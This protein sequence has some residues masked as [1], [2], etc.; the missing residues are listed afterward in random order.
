MALGGSVGTL[1]RYLLGAA[2]PHVSGVPIGIFAINISGALALGFVVQF[3]AQRGR[4]EGRR[5]SLRLLIGTGVLGGYTT[6]SLLAADIA[7]LVL[8][9][10]A[11]TGAGYGI[12]T[13][14]VGL[15]ATWCGVWLARLAKAGR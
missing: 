9:G 7:E 6:Y 14:I 1:I 12:A 3:L 13:L 10:N 2:I 15:A 8:D 5:R 11:W 4:D